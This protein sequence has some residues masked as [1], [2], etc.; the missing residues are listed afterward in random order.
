MLEFLKNICFVKLIIFK[1]IK[2]QKSLLCDKLKTVKWQGL[3]KVN[4]DFGT[5]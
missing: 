3:G 2:K 4:L 5:R 1:M